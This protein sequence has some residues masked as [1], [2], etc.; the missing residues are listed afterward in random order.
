MVMNQNSI[1]ELTCILIPAE[2]SLFKYISPSL[3]FLHV[4][5]GIIIME[6]MVIVNFL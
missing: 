5:W 2:K 1:V 6:D 3:S 4:S